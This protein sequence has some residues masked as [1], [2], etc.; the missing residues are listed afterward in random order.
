MSHPYTSLRLV[1]AG[2]TDPGLRRGLN[3]DA[4]QISDPSETS[5][6]REE[7]GWLFAVADGMGGHAAGEV[8]SKLAIDTLFELYYAESKSDMKK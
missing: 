1:A 3:E 4:W 7:R 5:D 2:C 8:A 6:L